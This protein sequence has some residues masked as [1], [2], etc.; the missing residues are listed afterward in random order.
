MNDCFLILTKQRHGRCVCNNKCKICYY[1]KKFLLLEATLKNT[2]TNIQTELSSHECKPYETK[3][4]YDR[5]KT[6][7]S[8]CLSIKIPETYEAR[9]TLAVWT[10]S[11]SLL[12]VSTLARCYPCT[13]HKSTQIHNKEE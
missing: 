7:F 13:L 11:D 5:D 1:S 8:H 3:L 9:E 2:Q 4:M 12:Y 6:C 10:L